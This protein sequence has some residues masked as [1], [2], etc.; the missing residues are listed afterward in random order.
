MPNKFERTLV[1]LKPD[2][3][4]RGITGE[5]L[6]RFEQKGIKPVGM[7][8]VKLSDLILDK[9]YAQHRGK[10]FFEPT[11]KYM[12]MLPV[13]LVVLEGLD[14]VKVVRTMC[15]PTDG[16]NAPPGTIRGDYSAGIS[17]NIIHSSEDGEAAD[18]EIK[19]YFKSTEIFGYD[20]LDA[21]FYYDVERG[22]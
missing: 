18:R 13:V 19:L 1:I 4:H 7:K 16:R 21:D 2:A 5:I 22:E 17:R 3:I 14:I 10:H 12:K 6:D 8:M 15:G 9:H 20:K 11:K